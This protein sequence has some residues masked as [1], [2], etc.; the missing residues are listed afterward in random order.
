MPKTS[1][2]RLETEARLQ[3]LEA[4]GSGRLFL[5]LVSSY[6][7][8]GPEVAGAVVAGSLIS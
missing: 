4:T 7:L 3:V 1:K 5:K 6:L 2:A 8:R